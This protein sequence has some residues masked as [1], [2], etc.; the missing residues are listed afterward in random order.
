MTN[1][2]IA[3][4]DTHIG[5]K[6]YNIPELEHDLRTLLHNAVSTAIEKKVRYFV[7]CGDL[8]DQMRPH[9]DLVAFVSDEMDRLWKAKVTP[10]AIS[11]DHDKRINEHSWATNVNKF[12]SGS[13]CKSIIGADYNDDPAVVMSTIQTLLEGRPANT[14]EWVF[15]HGQA[16]ELWPFCEEKKKLELKKLDLDNQFESFKGFIMGDIHKP[17]ETTLLISKDGKTKEVYAGYCGSLGVVKMDEVRTDC[18]LYFDGKDLTRLT[19]ELPRQ[20]VR[21]EIDDAVNRLTEIKDAA[22]DDKLKP[23]LVVSYNKTSKALLAKISDFYKFA[24]VKTLQV[25]DKAG[26]TSEDIRSE[27]G[28]T[29]RVST[30]LR[31]VFPD[32]ELY[33]LA[34]QLITTDPPETILDGFKLK[35]LEDSR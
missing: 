35:Y 31:E 11:G 7:V 21:L 8:Y 26:S 18:M 17:T 29:D 27:V 30:V 13:M 5:A 25:L 14:I 20:Y 1:S 15:L 32:D 19:Y 12:V 28:S 2:F 6:L 24:I 3:V 16:P 33:N 10:V 4:A 9:A 22:K 34:Y 23:L